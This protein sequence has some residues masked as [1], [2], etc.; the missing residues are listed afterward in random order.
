AGHNALFIL[1]NSFVAMTARRI[2]QTITA[3]L[4]LAV[5]I[6]FPSLVLSIWLTRKVACDAAMV[7]LSDRARFYWKI[8]TILF[9][10]SAYIAYRLTRPDITLVTCENCGKLRRPDMENCHRCGCKWHIPELTAP[11]W[12]VV[13]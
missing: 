7:G 2:D 3:K 4:F 12:R 6:I 1:P 11:P 10:L 9:G 8:G 13:M 5:F